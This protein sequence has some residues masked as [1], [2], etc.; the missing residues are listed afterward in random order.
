MEILIVI[1]WVLIVFSGSFLIAAFLGTYIHRQE[2]LAKDAEH[3]VMIERRN[4]VMRESETVNRRLLP[5]N[6][7]PANEGTKN[8]VA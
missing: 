1:G 8:T 2:Q 4:Q 5:T 3:R 6:Q 7:E